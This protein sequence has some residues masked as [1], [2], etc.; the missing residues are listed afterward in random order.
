[1]ESRESCHSFF[2][3]LKVVLNGCFWLRMID[4]G[5]G[6]GGGGGGKRESKIF[7]KTKASNLIEYLSLP[8]E[9]N[10]WFIVEEI[11][12]RVIVVRA[13]KESKTKQTKDHKKVG[14]KMARGSI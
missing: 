7:S 1:M 9:T 2:L 3:E 4:G 11:R 10:E 6:G 12:A 13:S 5:C 14:L 8:E